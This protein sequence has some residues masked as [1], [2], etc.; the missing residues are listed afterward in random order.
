MLLLCNSLVPLVAFL[1]AIVSPHFVGLVDGVAVFALALN[2]SP[3]DLE[4][5]VDVP[6]LVTI[7]HVF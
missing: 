2:C 4:V 7:W 3:L 1:V 6:F 5:K